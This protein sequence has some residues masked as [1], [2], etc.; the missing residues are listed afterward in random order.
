[1]GRSAWKIAGPAKARGRVTDRNLRPS[2]HRAGIFEN[3]AGEGS[4][5]LREEGRAAF[6]KNPAITMRE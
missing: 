3:G 2:D 4:R 5:R 1:V 6:E